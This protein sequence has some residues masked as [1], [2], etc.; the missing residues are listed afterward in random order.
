MG[1]GKPKG[2]IKHFQFTKIVV[3]LETAEETRRERNVVSIFREI[4]RTFGQMNDN[5]RGLDFIIFFA[6][7]AV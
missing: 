2:L 4:K 5:Y 1:R 6:S 7:V 3:P